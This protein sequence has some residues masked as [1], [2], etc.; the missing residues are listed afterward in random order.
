MRKAIFS[1]LGIFAFLIFSHF[2]VFACSCPTVVGV[3]QELKWKLKQLQAVF[4]GKIIEINKIPQSRDVSVKIEVK[5]VWKG[6]LSKEVNIATPNNPGM[7]GA[8]FEIGKSYLVFAS[9]S[10]EGNLSTGLCLKNKE[11]EKATEELEILGKGKKPKSSKS[12]SK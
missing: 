6:L 1:L 3:E 8:S 9:H 4:S 12:L 7:C 2:N 5:E 10:A 11:L